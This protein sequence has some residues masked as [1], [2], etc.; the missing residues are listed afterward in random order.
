MADLTIPARLVVG[1]SADSNG[2]P[3]LDATVVLKPEDYD[4][5]MPPG[6]PGIDGPPG[7]PRATFVKVGQIANA[8]A[9]PTGLGADDR[10]KWWHRL[11]TNGMD[12]WTGTAWKHSP[13]AVGVTGPAAAP[14]VLTPKPV[15]R[16]E[17]YTT[18]TV[19]LKGG[20]AGD[21]TILYTV[22]AGLRGGAGPFGASGAIAESP[23]YD[24]SYA[25]VHGSMFAYSRGGQR[26]RPLMP[27][28][29]Y[30]PYYFGPDAITP[31]DTSFVST[32]Q[33]VAATLV[34]PAMPFDYRP[35]VT[36]S[37]RA[38]TNGAS[39]T[40]SVMVRTRDLDGQIVAQFAVPFKNNMIDGNI[41]PFFGDPVAQRVSPSNGYAIVPAYEE[42]T[43]YVTLERTAGTAGLNYTQADGSV[44]VWCQP[45]IQ[46]PIVS[47]PTT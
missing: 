46:N 39:T 40:V 13:N 15:L 45:V 28:N 29:G 11:D 19:E 20:R 31:T 38:G 3:L 18:A 42:M 43:Y 33:L 6:P 36:G 25:P 37:F 30:G 26:F 4:A 7:R 23:D 41:L 22:P 16:D 8:A 21:Q 1:S 24:P 5:N 27:P 14:N 17:T 12:V 9:R 10:G 35:I 2:F 34:V 32:D 47:Q 44:S